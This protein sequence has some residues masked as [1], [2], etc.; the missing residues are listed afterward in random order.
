MSLWMCEQHNEVNEKLGKQ[1]FPCNLAALD[2]RWRV[3]KRKECWP[4]A[5]E[6]KGQQEG[7]K[8][9][10]QTKNQMT[11]SAPSTAT[12]LLPAVTKAK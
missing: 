8:Q 11:S 9:A 2:E 5:Q 6:Q 7:Q 1:K 3:S 4:A 10:Q 12:P